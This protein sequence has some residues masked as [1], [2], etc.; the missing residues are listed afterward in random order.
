MIAYTVLAVMLISLATWLFVWRVVH[1]PLGVLKAGTERLTHG[2]LGF[3]IEPNSNDEV[4][5]LAHSFNEMSS[6]LQQRPRRNHCLEPYPGG[7]RPGEDERTQEGRGADVARG[8]DGDHR[9]DGRGRCA[10]D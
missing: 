10:R 2:D 4:G 9:Q 5:E 7:S 1:E 8:E 6:Q 3:Q